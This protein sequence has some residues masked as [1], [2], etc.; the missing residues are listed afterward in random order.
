MQS[1]SRSARRVDALQSDEKLRQRGGET[2]QIAYALRSGGV[3]V[4]P[5]VDGPSPRIATDPLSLRQ[6]RGNRKRQQGRQLRQPAVFLFHLRRIVR[7][8]RK[9]HDHLVAQVKASVVPPTAGD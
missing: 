5:S 7:R 4:D 9:A 8:A 2:A 3:A 6:R 1:G